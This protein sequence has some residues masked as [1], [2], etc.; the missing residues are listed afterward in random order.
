EARR[1]RLTRSQHVQFRLAATI[2]EVEVAADGLRVRW[3]VPPRGPDLD[4]PADVV[5][6]AA[7]TVAEDN[8]ELAEMLKVPLTAEGFF[9]EA[10]Q[11]LRPIDFTTEGIFLCGAAHG[12]KRIDETIAQAEA[13]AAR[14][15][16][17]LSKETLQ[18]GGVV[19]TIDT[20]R[21]SACLCCVRACPYEVPVINA[22]GVAEIEPAR[23]QGCGVCAGE[24]PG[25][26]IDL[27][28]F[29]D[30]Q[31]LAMSEAFGEASP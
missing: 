24:C 18:V 19:S 12:P 26:A 22:E 7:P 16:T 30:R 27:H 23:C 29:T 20:D 8:A 1:A 25:K 10:H 21:C 15:A 14:A 17:I 6:L 5:V 28:H 4:L 13:A 11:K 2:A 31:I 9:L 3:T